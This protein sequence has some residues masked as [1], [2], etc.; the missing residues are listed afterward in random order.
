MLKSIKYYVLLAA[1]CCL[2]AVE[3]EDDCF[4]FDGG[5]TL[6]AS[7]DEPDAGLSIGDVITVD[8]DFPATGLDNLGRGG[9]GPNGGLVHTRVLRLLPGSDTLGA[10]VSAF[11][12]SSEN[13]TL[14]TAPTTLRGGWAD[15]RFTCPDERCRFRLN[16]R[17]VQAGQYILQVN[18]GGFEEVREEFDYCGGAIFSDT[19]LSNRRGP[20][21]DT[22]RVFISPMGPSE[23]RPEIFSFQPNIHLFTVSE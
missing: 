3:C 17:A 6:T 11:D 7:V 12:V 5:Y 13:G 16:Y 23:V 21:G 2:F 22:V 15:W 4:F 8:A 20:S 1:C 10:A 9:V 19:E 18:G 14:M